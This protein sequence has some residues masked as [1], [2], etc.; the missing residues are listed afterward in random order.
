LRG[1]LDA[2][3][4]GPTLVYFVNTHTARLAAATPSYR[5]VLERAHL[6][7]IDG[8][9]IRIACWLRGRHPRA[10]LV[11]TDLV[12]ALLRARAGG[13]CFLFG[14]TRTVNA[15]AARHVERNFPG[16]TIVGHRHGFDGAVSAADTLAA[17]NASGCELLLVGLGNP[18]QEEWLD[19]NASQLGPVLCLGV[20]GLFDHWAGDLKRARGW[21]RTLGLEWVQ[22]CLQR[23]RRVGRY[24]ADIPVFLGRAV[25]TAPR[26]RALDRPVS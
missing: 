24:A 11:G 8:I 16:W 18:L 13:R 14:G 4:S 7:L 22:L 23:P 17:I 5:A 3:G 19:R 10:N 25:W 12:P 2:P 9:G 26:D 15:A 21:I 6:L 20:G 1:V